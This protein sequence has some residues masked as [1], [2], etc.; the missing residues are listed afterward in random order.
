MSHCVAQPRLISNL[1]SSC[2][3]PS[4]IIAP[5]AAITEVLCVLGTC[6]PLVLSFVFIVIV[7]GCGRFYVWFE[8]GPYSIGQ[9][10]LQLDSCPAV[11][12]PVALAAVV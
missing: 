4:V 3:S 7:L 1:S 9:A 5:S 8:I 12:I 11:R 2:L 10:A 6:Q